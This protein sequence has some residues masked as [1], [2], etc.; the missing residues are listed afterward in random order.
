[1]RIELVREVPEAMKPRRIAIGGVAA[2]QT[3]D[4]KKAA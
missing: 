2:P 3:I 1:L 4:Q